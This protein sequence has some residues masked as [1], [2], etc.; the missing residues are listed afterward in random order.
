MFWDLYEQTK[1]AGSLALAFPKLEK[2]IQWHLGNRRKP[3]SLL[4]FWSQACKQL[5]LRLG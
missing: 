2:Y 4:M 3:G 5:T 1:D